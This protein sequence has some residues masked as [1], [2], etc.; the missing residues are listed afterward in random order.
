MAAYDIRRP[1]RDIDLQAVNL[2]VD[3][4]QCRRIVQAIADVAE[5][6][7]VVFDGSPVS[8]EP[9]RDAAPYAGLRVSVGVRIDMSRM[10]VKIDISAGDP[11]WPSVLT[12]AM[13]EL[14]GGAFEIEAH[15]PSTII[16]EKAVTIL[17]RGVTSTRWR[18]YVDPRAFAL[19][20]SLGA[21]DLRYAI[22]HVA[23]HRG[24]T[25]TTLS[26]AVEG[27]GAVAQAR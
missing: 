4:A 24:V 12:V 19:T 25:I 7:G 8:V 16:A 9:I 17:Q 26:R 10:V 11:I 14:L 1:T 2:A 13:P 27:H 21:E 22:Q 6:D 20:R 18:D 15:P 5:T 23:N 3:G